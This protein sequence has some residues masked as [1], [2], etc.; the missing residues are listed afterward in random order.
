MAKCLYY[1]FFSVHSFSLQLVSRFDYYT[2]PYGKKLVSFK[3]NLYFLSVFFFHA[4][5]FIEHK[6]HEFTVKPNKDTVFG[7]DILSKNGVFISPVFLRAMLACPD[8]LSSSL[9]SF[10]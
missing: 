10:V 8:Q 3:E 4:F 5:L 1:D 6:D 7:A 2:F 9:P